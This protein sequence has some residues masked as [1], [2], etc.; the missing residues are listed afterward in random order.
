[1]VLQLL[2]L[3]RETKLYEHRTKQKNGGKKTLV[4]TRGEIC[5]LFVEIVAYISYSSLKVTL[6]NIVF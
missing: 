3:L 4:R 5:N 2:N 1:M 6:E